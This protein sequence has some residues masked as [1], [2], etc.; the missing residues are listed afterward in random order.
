MAI[1]VVDVP[2]EDNEKLCTV[3]VPVAVKD[4]E[5]FPKSPQPSTSMGITE[6]LPIFS[7]LLKMID[8][9]MSNSQPLHPVDPLANPNANVEQVNNSRKCGR[10]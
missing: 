2:K 9:Y 3:T 6:P 5:L 4:V 8:G 10:G 1:D 7:D